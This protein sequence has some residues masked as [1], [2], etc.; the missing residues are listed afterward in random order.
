MKAAIE[1]L[2]TAMVGSCTCG[3][4]SPVIGQ[5]DERCTYRL[6]HEAMD[7]IDPVPPGASQSHFRAPLPTPRENEIL[8]ILIEECAEVIQR[9]TKLKRFGATE[10]QPW[11][12]LTNSQ[13]LGIEIGN[14]RVMVRLATEAGLIDSTS[15]AVGVRDKQDKLPKFMRYYEK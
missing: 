6:I 10:I 9:A 11:Q 7:M 4:K 5:H 3:T 8:D 14:L 13:R 1:K 15:I 12:D 2:T